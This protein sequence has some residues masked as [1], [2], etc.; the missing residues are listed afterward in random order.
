MAAPALQRSPSSYHRAVSNSTSAASS[1]H[2]LSGQRS[3]TLHYDREGSASY[4]VNGIE[5]GAENVDPSAPAALELFEKDPVFSKFLSDDFNAAQFASEAL[6]SESASAASEKLEEGIRLLE[7]QLRNEVFFRHDQLLQQLSTLK[8]TESVLAVVRAG[9]EG[10][11]GSVQR[12]RSEIAEPYKQIKLKSRQLN[13]LHDTVELLRSVIKALKRLKQ[14]KE[15]MDSVNAKA[16]LAKAAELFNEIETLRKEAD[17]SGVEVIEEEVPWLMEV[18]NRIRTEAMNS[19]EAG[20]EALN[21]AEVGSVLQVYFNMG[22]LKSTVE[23]LIN[24]YKSQ[25]IK[26]VSTAL[27]MK[28]IS[29]TMGGGGPGGVQ[30][31]GT[32]QLGATSRAREGL[33]QRL[34]TCISQLKTIMLA[35]WHLQRVLA[36]KRDPISHTVFLDEVTQGGDPMLT[37]RVWEALVKSFGTQMKSAFT[38]SSFVKETFVL[39]YPKLLALVDSLLDSIVRETDVKGVPPAIKPE[40]RTQLI[41]ALEPFQT[42]YLAKCLTRLS[43]HVNSMFPSTVRGSVP[44]Q[45]QIGR[46]ILRIQEEIEAAKT[47][48]RLTVLVLREVSKI[49]Q[50]LAERS[51]YQISAGPDSRQVS[52]PATPLQIKNFTLCLHLQ[53][54]HS[55]LSTML[56][57]LPPAASETLSAAM[58]SIYGVALDS[59]TPLFRS[60]VEK[61]ESC[62]LQIHDQNF[63][64]DTMDYVEG[65][66]S[67]SKYMEDLQRA[68]TLFRSEFLSKLMVGSS[69]AAMGGES[70]CSSLARKMASRVLLFFVRHAA[71]VRPLS[72]SGKLRMARDMAELE[73]VVGQSLYPVEQLGAP[74]HALRA[75]RPL[76]FLDTSQLSGSPLLKE[77]PLS[78]VLHHLYSRGP[79]ELESPVKKLRLSYQ[80]YSL[81]LDNQGD[82]QVWKGIKSTLDDY[83][84]KVRAR[85]DKEFSPVTF[86]ERLSALAHEWVSHIEQLIPGIQ[87]C[88]G[89]QHVRSLS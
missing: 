73:L 41:A 15:L 68:I 35:V 45:E 59:I 31:S 24:K 61:L 28:A 72:E 52:G 89:L 75:F 1:L 79:D 80:Q 63:S 56:A 3:L 10:L 88:L 22:E 51:E 64:S 70:I 78:V 74:Y 86:F 76:I 58:G 7:K 83:A 84:A 53:E 11:Q 50:L 39:G 19:L 49:L 6:G 46:L 87:N 37:E 77:L 17:L 48:G 14:L 67:T 69:S 57:S 16:D 47:D 21:Q 40:D 20:M 2:R 23:I 25:A 29:S 42:A 65:E 34:G 71:L 18:G 54:V 82:E 43:E 62:I 81:W 13:S 33:W 8:E 4:H 12:V 27:D 36:K 9:V 26:S 66:D 60:M 55:R 85:G 44:T 32:P 38:A 5:N 30:R